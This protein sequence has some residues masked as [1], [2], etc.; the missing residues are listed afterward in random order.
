MKSSAILL[1]IL[2]LAAVGFYIPYA[3][4]NGVAKFRDDP[5]QYKVA[6]NAL[7]GYWTLNRNP[8]AQIVTP[9]ARV[10]RVWVQPGHCHD[11][12][13]SDA[14][15]DYRAEVQGLSWFG[16]P[17]PIVDVVCGGKQWARRTF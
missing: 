8:I 16:I 13:A 14:S 4:D 1:A 9:G 10:K 7:Q 12:R 2:I 5:I 15:A 17:G 11:P 3:T 6:V